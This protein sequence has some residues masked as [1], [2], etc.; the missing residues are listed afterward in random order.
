ML[1]NDYFKYKMLETHEEAITNLST[2]KTYK[3]PFTFCDKETFVGIEV[4]VEGVHTLSNLG[5]VDSTHY[6]W[7]NVEDNSLRNNGREFVSLPIRGD[8]ISYALSLLHNNLHKSINC[9]GHEFSE[10]TS[11]HVHVNCRT[12]T[13]EQINTLVLAYSLVE[14]VIYD[15]VGGGRDDNIFCV[16]LKDTGISK[17]L[18]EGFV[19]DNG[20]LDYVTSWHKYAGLNLVPLRSYGTVE[21]RHMTGTCDVERLQVWI[22]MILSLRQFAIKTP[23]NTLKKLALE[24]NT[25]SEYVQTLYAIFGNHASLLQ[26]ENT[27]QSMEKA[28]CFVKDCF[29]HSENRLS[30]AEYVNSTIHKESPLL[31]ACHKV[32]LI[33]FR[34]NKLDQLEEEL[35]RLKQGFALLKPDAPLYKDYQ[36]AIK[37][38]LLKI[39]MEKAQNEKIKSVPLQDRIRVFEGVINNPQWIAV[40]D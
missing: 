5:K 21:F 18:S 11:V 26:N 2:R 22:D 24:L 8:N 9:I 4:E 37:D 16:P 3:S 38:T 15:F 20:L 12:L 32:G 7:K 27:A 28:C 39:K 34:A 17:L 31:L 36:N 10:R 30:F 1:C 29:G 14:P 33:S 19:A 40:G 35:A 25:S 13:H 6:L 23:F